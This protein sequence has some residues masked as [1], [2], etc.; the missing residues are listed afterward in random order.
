METGNPYFY[1]ED[2]NAI[3]DIYV[4]FKFY[5]EFFFDSILEKC[6]I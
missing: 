6:T 2:T 3:Y 4:L 5:N 1:S